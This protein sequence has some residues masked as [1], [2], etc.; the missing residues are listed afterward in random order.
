MQV[1]KRNGDIVTF[2][3]KKI[4][5]AISKAGYVDDNTKQRIV[6]SISSIGKDTIHVE[7]IQDLVEMKLMNSSYKNVAKEYVRYRYKR[8]IIRDSEGINNSILEILS[9]S[10]EYINGENSNKNPA[11]LSTQRDYMAGEVSKDISRR[12]LLPEDVLEAHDKGIIHFHDMDYFAQSMHNCCLVNLEDMMQ[13]GTVVSNTM[14]E[15]P[16]SFITA[17]NIAT[18]IMAQVAS[19]QYGGQSESLAHLAPF[20]DISRKRIRKEIEEQL[21]HTGMSSELVDYLAPKLTEE[22]V[23]SEVK[24]GVQI[25]QYQIL[26]LMTTN[27]QTPFVTIWMYLGEVPEG[28]TRDDLAMIRRSIITEDQRY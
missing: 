6:S 10:N 14:I 20:V 16:H 11:I 8:E 19:N 28:Q 13:N 1:I 26:T 15:K 9:S 25:I 21:Y 24:Q 18:Q 27:G 7:E 2:D 22:R 17:C 3:E 12:L 5:K 23:K 4:L